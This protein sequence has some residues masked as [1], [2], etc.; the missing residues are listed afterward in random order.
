MDKFPT[1]CLIF[2]LVLL[3]CLPMEEGAAKAATNPRIEQ[4]L[5]SGWKFHLGDAPAV[6]AK[7]LDETGWTAINLP[8]T[9]N[10]ADGQDG[11]GNYFAA[12]DGIANTSERQPPGQT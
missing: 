12:P 2:L 3:V 7:A 10:A 9:W 6:E 1:H 4:S 11:G 8:H 5:N